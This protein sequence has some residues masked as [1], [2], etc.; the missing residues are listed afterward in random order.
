MARI[1]PDGAVGIRDHHAVGNP[2]RLG[3]LERDDCQRAVLPPMRDPTRTPGE[4]LH[5]LAVPHGIE[6][7]GEDDVISEIRIVQ[8]PPKNPGLGRHRHGRVARQRPGHRREYNRVSHAVG[9][10][11]GV[12]HVDERSDL[13]SRP[14]AVGGVQRQTAKDEGQQRREGDARERL[15]LMPE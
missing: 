14:Q 15:A 8:R 10:K 9:A 11:D 2:V 4:V 6:V 1:V 3:I 12:R 7:V 5:E 13:G